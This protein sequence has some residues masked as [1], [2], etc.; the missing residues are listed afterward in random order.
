MV[1]RVV[2]TKLTEEEHEKL[3]DVCNKEG[4]TPF[5][6]LKK[7]IINKVDD[8]SDLEK[9]EHQESIEKIKPSESKADKDLRR[10]LGIRT[11]AKAL[12][13]E[14]RRKHTLEE[15]LDHMKNCRNPDCKYGRMNNLK[16]YR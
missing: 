7:L 11:S 2:S 4:C 16:N 14:T 5:A 12:E 10:I 6:M 8:E 13:V 9:I 1:Y 15:T 3:L